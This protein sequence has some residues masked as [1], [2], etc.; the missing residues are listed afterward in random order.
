LG[1]WF[2]VERV[3]FGTGAPLYYWQ[4]SRLGLEGSRLSDQQQRG[5]LGQNALEVFAWD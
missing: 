5:I 1:T 4:G 3:L 2:P